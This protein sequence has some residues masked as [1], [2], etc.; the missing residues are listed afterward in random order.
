VFM[1]DRWKEKICLDN[2]RSRYRFYCIPNK[3]LP[4]HMTCCKVVLSSQKEGQGRSLVDHTLI[5]EN[6]MGGKRI[7]WGRQSF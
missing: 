3:D 6:T 1:Y 7:F 5:L 4:P 2:D